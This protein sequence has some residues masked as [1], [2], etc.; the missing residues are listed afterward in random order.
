MS[1]VIILTSIIFLVFEVSCKARREAGS[2][3]LPGLQEVEK[4]FAEVNG[5]LL[6]Y[7]VAG[8]GDHIVLVHGNFG[9]CRYYDSQFEVFARNYRVLRYDVRGYGKSKLPDL[10]VPYS[11]FEDLKALMEYLDIPKAHIAGFS[12]GSGIAVDFVLAYPEMCSSLIPIGPWAN[13]YDSPATASLWQEFGTIMAAAKENGREAALV[14]VLRAHWWRPEKVPSP[15]MDRLKQ[16]CDDYSFWHFS[17]PDPR[18]F[19]DPPAVQ[20]LDRI[21]VPVLIITAQYDVDACREIA[22]LMEDKIPNSRKV[23]FA[24]ATHMMLME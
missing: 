1:K 22:D 12:M 6:Y 18:L 9:D 16:I 2:E 7:E 20:Q 19:L 4:G 3:S 17:N 24:G 13:G 5:T 21:K 8:S 11:D 15:V 10:G 14:E 23:D